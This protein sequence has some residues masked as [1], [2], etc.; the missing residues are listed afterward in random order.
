MAEHTRSGEIWVLGATGRIGRSVV[1]GLARQGVDPVLV[2]RRRAAL[3]ALQAGSGRENADKIVVADG[4]EAIADALRA[5]RP[6]VVVNLIGNY[7]E[8]ARVFADAVLPGG[9]YVDLAADP[10]AVP[11]VLDRHGEAVDAGSTLVTGAGFGVL[12]AEAVVAALCA[13]R[14]VP[15][16][17]R[18]D[19]LASVAMEAGVVGE[20]FASSM[21]EGMRNGGL[22]YENGRLVKTRLGADPKTLT[23]P[24]GETAKSAGA[25]TGELFAAQR[26]SG[27]PAVTAT[28]ALAPTSPVVRAVLPVAG[29]LLSILPLRRFLVRQMAQAKMKASPRPRRH[30][31]GHA[32][33]TWPDGTVREGWLRADDGMDYTAAVITE[34]AQRLARGEGRPG[35]YTP[36]AAFGAD[37][38]VSA[39]GTF[40]PA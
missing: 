33:V 25:A 15:D 3:V 40:V 34:V 1:A 5:G 29:A 35:A 6:A 22:R 28:S 20:A 10:V 7:A 9:H 27:A 19:A 30:S 14:P 23:L 39:G 13:D 36:A 11:Q 12:A 24:D 18:V 21:I 31:W 16:H 26:V 8:T 38:A 37:V 32:V 4:T 2:G 17:V